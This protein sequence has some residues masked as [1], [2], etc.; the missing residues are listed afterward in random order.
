M[1]GMVGVLDNRQMD[2]KSTAN[3]LQFAKNTE[4]ISLQKAQIFTLK[5]ELNAELK[6]RIEKI[7]ELLDNYLDLL[8]KTFSMF[9]M[10]VATKT[11]LES[12][13]KKTYKMALHHLSNPG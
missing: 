1:R 13:L 10:N 12:T 5:A 9:H 4:Q 11:S 2:S 3:L 8:S 6:T 7:E